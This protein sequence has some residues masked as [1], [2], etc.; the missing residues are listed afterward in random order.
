MREVCVGVFVVDV[1]LCDVG[2][3]TGCHGKIEK[4]QDRWIVVPLGKTIKTNAG[5]N[6]QALYCTVTLTT[7]C[8]AMRTLGNYRSNLLHCELEWRCLGQYCRFSNVA[9]TVEWNN[10][11]ACEFCARSC[12]LH[13]S[14]TAFAGMLPHIAT[15]GA[16]R[17]VLRSLWAPPQYMVRTHYGHM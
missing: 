14:T 12:S 4:Q 17:H 9:V 6:T 2:M 5:T 13:P 11:T 15:F 8:T 1:L 7:P 16:S 3:L 10:C